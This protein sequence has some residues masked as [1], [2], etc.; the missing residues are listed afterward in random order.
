MKKV[1]QYLK[2]YQ[3]EHFNWEMY[4]VILLFCATCIFFNYRYDF[5]D[6]VIDSYSGEPIKWLWMF[7][8][9]GTPFFCVCLILY[10]FGKKRDW[11]T[12]K[13]Y[14][15]K[16]IVGFG[17]LSFDRSFYGF[18][19]LLS[20][21]PRM[22]Y[23]FVI[24]CVNWASSLILVV[25]PMLLLYPLLEKDN[26]KNYYGLVWRKFDARPY[27]AL[28]AIAAV[29]IGIGSFLGDIQDYYPRYRTAGGN[30]YL[31]DNPDLNESWLVLIYELCYGSNFISVELIFRGF[32]IFAFSRTLG[33]YAV[34]PMVATYAFLHFGKPMGETISSLF[35][36]YV[37]GIISY[38]S[39]NIWGGI[40]IH[41]GVAW[42]MELFGW[43]HKL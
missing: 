19:Y 26:H 35:G 30:L 41:L 13:N 33:G 9:H 15:I 32:L 10:A 3:K 20:E 22:E 17:L 1:I 8:F 4:S 34:L 42:L 12:S 37:L 43:F 6:G 38:N 23:P 7:L 24:R 39:R 14:W 31:R 29:F 2:E 40:F 16:F 36:G 21:V 5:E 11:L 18:E 27:L 28:L 25:I